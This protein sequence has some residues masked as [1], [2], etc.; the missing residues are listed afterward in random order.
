MIH[1]IRY[2]HIK[3]LNP[4]T[5]YIFIGIFVSFLADYLTSAALLLTLLLMAH[6]KSPRSMLQKAHFHYIFVYISISQ[7]LYEE[8]PWIISSKT[9]PFLPWKPW[10]PYISP[11][12]LY[13][14]SNSNFL[15][16]IFCKTD[17]FCKNLSLVKIFY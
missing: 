3:K 2:S 5:Q 17:T 6:A 13:L 15:P 14:L 8:L 11:Y 1:F 16:Q 12:F 10:K 9:S 7:C 4:G